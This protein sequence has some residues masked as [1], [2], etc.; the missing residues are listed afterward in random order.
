MKYVSTRDISSSKIPKKTYTFKEAIL[1]GWG[2][3]GGMIVPITIPKI[4]QGI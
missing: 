4:N 3:D 1:A 2:E